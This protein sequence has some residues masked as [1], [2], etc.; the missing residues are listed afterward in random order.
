MDALVLVGGEG[1]RLRPLTAA[2]PK[3]LLPVAGVP[4]IE[5]VVAHLA[6]H[7][8]SHVVLSMGYR[9]DAFVEAY[10]GGTCAGVEITYAIEP[11]L[12]DTAGA[13]RFAALDAGLEDTF[14]VV[15]GDV[16]TQIDVS[17]LARFHRLRGAQATISLTPVEDPSAYGVVPTDDSGRVLAF[18][19]KPARDD[20]PTN[21]INAGMYVL[22]PSVLDL[23]ADDRRVSI[24]RETFP[25]LVA[26]GR[27]YALASDAYWIDTG[28]PASY[29]QANLDAI[30]H[31]GG[32]PVLGHGVTVAPDAVIER[33][34]IGAGSRVEAGAEVRESVVLPGACIG[35]GAVVRR[36]IL[37]RRVTIGAGARVDDQTVVGDGVVV[38]PGALLSGVRV[39][40]PA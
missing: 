17:A 36:S 8:V 34:V 16:M 30:D 7:G 5:R 9:P 39:P 19:E 2:T 33:S 11:E 28:T 21:L 6:G 29:L 40:E 31:S 4:M 3:Q 1:T 37:G 35:A 38:D 22:E 25:A 23:V 20:A 27:L 15:N 10:P 32:A 26:A 24:E 18:I 13:V 14:L 12:L